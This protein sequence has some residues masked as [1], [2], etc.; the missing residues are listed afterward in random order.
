MV[1][2]LQASTLEPL[3][4][5]VVKAVEPQKILAEVVAQL[6]FTRVSGGFFSFLH[7]VYMCPRNLQII[8]QCKIS[9][10]FHSVI[11]NP[12]PIIQPFIVIPN[13]N[14]SISPCRALTGSS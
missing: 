10:L 8:G 13:P 1:G 12:T 2:A 5:Q 4:V 6:K 9:E 14:P 11:R 7:V 3:W